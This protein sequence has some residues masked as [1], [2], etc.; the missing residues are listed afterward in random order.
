[1]TS[2]SGSHLLVY[3]FRNE[4]KYIT[5]T[6]SFRTVIISYGTLFFP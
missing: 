5:L 1:M 4:F 3:I 6:V 2:E